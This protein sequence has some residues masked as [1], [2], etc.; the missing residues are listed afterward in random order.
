MGI[1][2]NVIY[3]I[4]ADALGKFEPYAGLG[5]GIFHG[6]ETHFGSN[7]IVGVSVNMLSGKVF[8]D[9][10]ARSLTKQNQVAV[11]YSFTF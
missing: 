3:N 4:K 10:S 5:L 9:Y 11:G 8:F 2:G 7:V 1:S 6:K